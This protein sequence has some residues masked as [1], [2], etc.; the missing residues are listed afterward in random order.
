[1]LLG[2]V[3]AQGNGY[4]DMVDVMEEAQ[5]EAAAR[6]G[7]HFIVLESRSDLDSVVIS[8]ASANTE[9]KPTYGGGASATTTFRPEQRIHFSRES[10]GIAVFFVPYEGLVQLPRQLWPVAGYHR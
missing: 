10:I 8:Q 9:I 1:M 7:T 5:L 3:H 2:A 6:G 4:A